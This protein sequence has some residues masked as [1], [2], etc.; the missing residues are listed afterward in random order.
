MSLLDGLAERWMGIRPFLKTPPLH[1]NQ[2]AGFIVV[3]APLVIAVGWRGWRT[4]SILGWGIT[5]IVATLILFALLLTGS[6]GAWLALIVALT[7]WGWS[8]F[9]QQLAQRIAPSPRAVFWLG[10]AIG[11]AVSLAVIWLLPDDLLGLANRLPGAASANS[12]AAIF[13]NTLHLLGDFPFIGG[14]LDAFAGLYSQYMLVIPQ[15]I[16]TYAHNLYLDVALEQGFLGLLALVVILVGSLWLL[17][18]QPDWPEAVD[19][20]SLLCWAVITG[21]LVLMGRGLVDDAFYGN[22]GTPLLWLLPG[23]AV[24]L[25]RA[26]TD[27]ADLSRLSAAQWGVVVGLLLVSVVTNALSPQ[28]RAA[29]VANLGAVEMSRVELSAWPTN[30]W[31]D[32]R[33]LPALQ[34]AEQRFTQALQLD[35]TNRTAHHR[36]GMIGMLRRDFVTAVAHLEAAYQTDNSHP[37]IRKSLAYSYIWNDQLNKAQTLLTDIP[38]AQN[39]LKVYVWWWGT[40]GRDDLVARAE[41]TLQLLK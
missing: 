11:L 30:E 1:P 16:F 7:V 33:S 12:R 38:E 13:S 19:H 2:A 27:G 32:G 22:R 17:S 39:E 23:M 4:R 29:W 20:Y 21:L 25:T 3:F 14:G 37:G 10:L 26:T 6:R 18:R 35:P 36:L 15:R 31:D 5:A 9:S 24:A 8:A 40:Q 34:S 28:W 41:Q